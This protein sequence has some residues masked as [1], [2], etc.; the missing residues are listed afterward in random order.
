MKPAAGLIMVAAA[1]GAVAGCW[2]IDEPTGPG[3]AILVNLLD[4]AFSPETVTVAVGKYVRWTNGG[5]QI[6]GVASDSAG[7]QSML[8]APTW[9]VENRFDTVGLYDIRCTVHDIEHGAVIVQ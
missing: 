2:Q 8:L 6:H 4:G 1:I 7:F 3:D 5:S 9:W